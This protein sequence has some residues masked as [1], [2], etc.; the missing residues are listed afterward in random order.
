MRVIIGSVLEIGYHTSI[1]TFMYGETE[2]QGRVSLPPCSH[3]NTAISCR[4]GI[5]TP[6]PHCRLLQ[7]PRKPNGSSSCHSEGPDP[8]LK[9]DVTFL[10]TQ[11]LGQNENDLINM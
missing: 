1:L 11:G 2:A 7:T 5:G 6:V 4:C 3:P 10:S 9:Y 8:S